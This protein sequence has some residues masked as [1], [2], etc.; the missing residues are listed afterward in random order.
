[1]IKLVSLLNEILKEV[2]D[3]TNIEP[4]PYSNN[5][6]RTDDDLRV[7][8]DIEILDDYVVNDIL[9]DNPQL[10]QNEDVV[11]NVSFDINGQQNQY[12]TTSY[13]EYIR[14]LKTVTLIVEEW[15]KNNP[16]VNILMFFAANKNA[17]LHFVSTDPQ[18]TKLYLT[19]IQKQLS[20]NNNW[21]IIDDIKYRYLN[22]TLEGIALIRK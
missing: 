4:Y 9:Y 16:S 3:L 17:K 15:M 21:I 11:A 8:V 2:G 13:K 20:K 14:I 1:M 7:H 18:K 10:P 12:T 19:I 22:S 5:K 6:F